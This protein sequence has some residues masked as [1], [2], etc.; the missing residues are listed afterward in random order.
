MAGK[1][2][3]TSA[4]IDCTT[5]RTL[6]QSFRRGAQRGKIGSR[7]ICRRVAAANVRNTICCLVTKE[8]T[9]AMML[10]PISACQPA[11]IIGFGF[12]KEGRS[13]DGGRDPAP[14]AITGDPLTA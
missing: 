6:R 9:I 7:R 8:G 4:I 10:R 5:F 2:D 14:P 3:E 1:R 11:Q 12:G 13:Q